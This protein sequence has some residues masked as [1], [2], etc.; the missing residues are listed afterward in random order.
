[1]RSIFKII[2]LIVVIA[3]IIFGFYTRHMYKKSKWIDG[4]DLESKKQSRIESF[5]ALGTFL[6]AFAFMYLWA[7]I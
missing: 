6:L 5:I 7:L 4:K 3:L 2:I 1:M